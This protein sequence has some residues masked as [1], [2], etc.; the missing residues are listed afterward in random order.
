[1][2]KNLPVTQNSNDYSDTARIVSTTNSKGVINYVNQ[3]FIDISGYSK[4]ELIGQ[5]HNLIRHP[6]M[7]QAAF[8]SM[9]D[10]L[11]NQAPWM[12]LVK[13][14]CKNGDYYWVDAFV[15][16]SG[17]Q[18]EGASN[19]QSVRFKPSAEQVERAET[20]YR[21]LNKDRLPYNTLHPRHWPQAAKT[22][23]LIWLCLLPLVFYTIY[24]ASIPLAVTAFVSVIA[25]PILSIIVSADIRKR[26]KAAHSIY[27][28]PL[29]QYIY[30]GRGDELGAIELSRIFIRNKLETA[31]W[32]VLDST[33]NIQIGAE[34]SLSMA[35]STEANTERQKAELDQFATAIN[36]MSA[37]IQEVSQS[38]QSVSELMQSVE[39]QVNLGSTQVN[40]TTTFV[41]K[42]AEDL[43]N[44]SSQ[45]QQINENSEQISGLVQQIHSIAEQ[46]NLLALNAAIEAAR[47]GEQGRGF[48]VVAD[49]VR[50][51]AS[52]TANTTEQI[53]QA[54]QDIQNGM[55]DAVGIVETTLKS[56]TATKEQADLAKSSL[57]EITNLTQQTLS[58]MLQS[59][60]ATEEQSAVC[61]EINENAHMIQ[62]TAIDTFGNAQ[63][64]QQE[65]TL[66]L[67]EVTKL[68]KLARDFTQ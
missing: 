43:S 34:N 54:I 38:T 49:E 2:R 35:K 64:A 31:L 20:C 26:A 21:R 15:M 39:T 55:H 45:V 30:T 42:L 9:W 23:A 61:S 48:A 60:S 17:E 29:A 53:Q 14:R 68:T 58:A 40:K 41:S 16:A 11:G 3:D 50:N 67:K 24:A 36:Q 65:Q 4:D 37:S 10:T 28:D 1:M 22:S 18:T 66:Q 57:D 52:S 27:H 44:T 8:K 5:A 12:G 6:D 62:S 47:A 7:P 19:L 51:L 46:T 25:A 59:A 33:K 56:S 13:N 63:S 32:R